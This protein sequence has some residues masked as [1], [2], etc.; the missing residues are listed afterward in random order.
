M[1]PFTLAAPLLLL[2]A[3][4][5][6]AQVSMDNRALDALQPAAPA[7]KAPAHPNTGHA[8]HHGA[9]H[10]AAKHAP[11]KAPQHAAAKPVPPSVPAAAP[12][13]PVIAPPPIVFPVHPAPP[14]PPVP[15]VV[16]A[17][18]AASQVGTM[19]RVTFGP[20]Q[21]DLNPATAA[22][23]RA[24]GEAAKADPAATISVEA[25]APGTEDDPS[26]P[27]RLSLS[28]ALAARA[29]LINAGVPS[30]HIYVRALGNTHIGDGP[31]DRVDLTRNGTAGTGHAATPAPATTPAPTAPATQ[32]APAGGGNPP[33]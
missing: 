23:I 19:T 14:P 15:V 33:R 30:T 10:P 28:R 32:P 27:R 25:Y 16:T 26:T 24:V 11:A 21:A 31:A 4:P 22:A 17:P 5:A 29:V 12:A 13:A 1:R 20:G 9:R 6:V 2:L 18:G 8:P 7:A 3:L